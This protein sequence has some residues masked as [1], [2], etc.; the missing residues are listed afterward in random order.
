MIKNFI[1]VIFLLVILF[2]TSN[3]GFSQS[4]SRMSDAQILQIMA[5]A[6]QKGMSQQELTMYAKSQ[7]YSDADISKLMQRANSS[8]AP[9]MNTGSNSTN[10]NLAQRQLVQIGDNNLSNTGSDS[11]SLLS[12]EES[13]IFGY[14]VFHNK[15]ISFTPNLNMATPKNYIVGP[16]DELAIQIYGIA[17][18]T[19]N[20]KVNPEG[21]V[22]IP[23]VGV[24]HVSGL[25]IE[26]LSALLTQKIG[27]RYAGVGGANPSSFLMVTLSNIRTIKVN[28]VG[29]VKTPGTYQLPGFTTSFNALYAAGGPTVKGSFRNIQLFRG[30]KQI[31]EVDLYDFLLKGITDKNIR[32]EDN[33]VLLVPQYGKRVEIAGEVRRNLFFEVKENETVFNLIEMANGY[34]NNAYRKMLTIQRSN[35]LDKSILNI[36][37][38]EQGTTKLFDG[39]YII[40]GKSPNI[41]K[42]RIQILGAV[43]REGDYELQTN[44]KISDLISQSGGLKPEAFRPRAILYRTEKDLQK[45]AISIDLYKALAKDSAN[46]IILIKEDL[47]VISSIY[48]IKEN[49]FVS[50]EGEVNQTGTFPY[51][52]GMTVSDLILRSNGF[53]EAASGSSIEIVRRVRDNNNEI[54]KIIKVDLNKDLSISTNEINTILEPFDQVFVRASVGFRE[55]KSVRV[56]GE[57][58]YTGQFTMDKAN[59]TV[60]DLIKRAGGALPSANVK[61]TLLIRRTIFFNKENNT[62]EYLNKLLELKSRYE[63]S[64]KSGFAESNKI[65]LLVLNKEIDNLYLKKFKNEKKLSNIGIDLSSSINQTNKLDTTNRLYSENR[66]ERTGQVN[67]EQ[68]KSDLQARVFENLRDIAINEDQYQFVSIDLEKII[69]E[70]R[71]GKYDV[72]L[73]EGD[74]LYIPTFNETVGVSGDVLYPIVIKYLQGN[75]LKNYVNLAGGFNNTALKGRSYVVEAN[76]AVKRT[77]R[78]FGL[79]FY[80]KVSPGSQV[81][82]PQNNKPKS[83]FSIDRVLGLVSSLV[84]TYLLVNNLTK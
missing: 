33:D 51:S 64:T 38:K 29:E 19:I 5:A 79:K 1:R 25:S 58:I 71:E 37:E 34:T 43:M 69:K 4:A 59:M 40:V 66:L 76:G 28:L 11:V 10:S 12:Y 15:G 61:G 57:A 70:T 16:G 82:V 39:D 7:G 50:I 13:K 77:H 60:G 48:D 81:F 42:N 24:S 78:F 68:L 17:Q 65:Q 35:G 3:F 6:N 75:S 9:G 80:P 84:T 21:K 8:N 22:V 49:Y 73:Q 20:L 63:D 2:T 18:A 45:R 67:I 62:D 46:D 26:A 56:Q 14:E 54:A 23:N 72:Q 41:Y 74:I 36:D 53:K 44:F 83:N 27:T 30:G 32:L 47:L 55:L 31:A 52:K